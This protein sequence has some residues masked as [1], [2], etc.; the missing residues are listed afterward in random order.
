[1]APDTDDLWTKV[2]TLQW[3]L[4][5][6]FAIENERMLYS[7]PSLQVSLIDIMQSEFLSIKFK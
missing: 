2:E 5:V 1:M 6:I 4:Y 3:V 7:E